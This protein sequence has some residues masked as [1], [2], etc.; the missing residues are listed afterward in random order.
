[1]SWFFKVSRGWAPYSAEQSEQIEAAWSLCQTGARPISEQVPL[2]EWR[3]DLEKM[4]F[5][6]GCPLRISDEWLGERLG[7]P[8]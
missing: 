7:D 1:M 8:P 2:G 5:C 4:I 3:V 6:Q